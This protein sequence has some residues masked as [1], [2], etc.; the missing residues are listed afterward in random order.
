M[1]PIDRDK[2][3]DPIRSGTGEDVSDDTV[4]ESQTWGCATRPTA[5][6]AL[7]NDAR[8]EPYVLHE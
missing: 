7:S 2:L 4:W 1:V 8:S 3:R 5:A 6:C